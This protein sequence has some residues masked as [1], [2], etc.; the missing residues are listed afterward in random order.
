MHEEK[1]P[2]SL[3]ASGSST[4]NNS[5]PVSENDAQLDNFYEMHQTDTKNT[6][7]SLHSSTQHASADREPS[8]LEKVE[9]RQSAKSFKEGGYGWFVCFSAFLCNVVSFGVGTSCG[10]WRSVMQNYYASTVFDGSASAVQL[11]FVGTIAFIFIN[12]MGPP[13]QILKSMIG[14][15]VLIGC[16]CLLMCLGLI[17]AGFSTQVWHLYLTQGIM[18]GL[19]GSAMYITMMGIVPQWFDKRRG[20]ALGLSASGSGIGGLIMPFIMNALLQ[21]YG[22]GWTYRI[23]GF[24]CLV[25]GTFA[26]C[27]VREKY[28]ST[29]RKKLS[30]IVQWSVLKDSN[31]VLWCVA[32]TVTLFGYLIPFFYLPA[33]ATSIGLSDAQGSSLIAMISGCNFVGRITTGYIGDRIGRLNMLIIAMTISA[34]CNLV[35]WPLSPFLSGLIAF[36]CIYGFFCGTYFTMMAAVTAYISKMERFPSAFSVFLMSNIAASFGPPI[37]GAIQSGTNPNSFLSVQMF[38]G[39][40]F[41]CGA[42]L[43]FVLKIKM[44]KAVFF[45][46]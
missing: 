35:I 36:S 37:A 39:C 12:G 18:F 23:I 26:T 40:C 15:R 3:D 42:I 45:K 14:A 24:M 41:L 30:D 2:E 10:K 29:G 25:L 16:G 5:D 44:T 9:T 8:Q 33:Y 28:P 43:M 46:V 17:L 13:M 11:T 32:A 20:L 6:A 1:H 4:I 34:L 7:A 19:G 31:L 27:L 21:K 38:G 22:G